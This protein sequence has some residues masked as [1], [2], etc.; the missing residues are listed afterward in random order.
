MTHRTHWG[1]ELSEWQGLEHTG[2]LRGLKKW[3]F[4][5]SFIRAHYIPGTRKEGENTA[6]F[7]I[8]P[9][10]LPEIR[11]QKMS[12]FSLILTNFSLPQPKII[13]PSAIFLCKSLCQ[14]TSC[15]NAGQHS[16][17]SDQFRD[18]WGRCSSMAWEAAGLPILSHHPRE[19]LLGIPGDQLGDGKYNRWPLN[20]PLSHCLSAASHHYQIGATKRGI[21]S[22]QCRLER[23]ISCKRASG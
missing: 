2:V 5:H 23:S 3:R 9:S 19:G 20:F 22:P 11:T 4:A 21:F 15:S 16:H 1:R 12:R 13:F 8:F 17:L 7:T 14:N 18:M 6:S 10:D